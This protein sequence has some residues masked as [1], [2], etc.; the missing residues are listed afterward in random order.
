M[1][2]NFTVIS[3][4]IF[5][6][7]ISPASLQKWASQFEEA[8][9]DLLEIM[10]KNFRYFNFNSLSAKLRALHERLI[11]RYGKDLTFISVGHPSK[12]GDLI[13]YFYR[14]EN[15]LTSDSFEQFEDIGMLSK[16]AGRTLVFLDD[17]SGSGRQAE[18]LWHSIR[19]KI[20]ETDIKAK[21]VYATIV[22]LSRARKR[23][24]INSHLEF[25]SELELGSEQALFSDD[26]IIVPEARTRDRLHKMA[27]KYG[28]RIYPSHPLGYSESG[29]LIA[30][31]YSTPN[32]TL[33]LFWAKTASWHPLLPH[34]EPLRDRPS[35]IG[36]NPAWL[37]KQIPPD[38]TTSSSKD[39]EHTIELALLVLNEFKSL[40]AV[41]A[42]LPIF[43]ALHLGSGVARK[44]VELARDLANTKNEGTA[45]A[46]SILIPHSMAAVPLTIEAPEKFE[47]GLKAKLQERSRGLDG[48]VAAVVVNEQGFVQGITF[49]PEASDGRVGSVPSRL[50]SAAEMSRLTKSLIIVGAGDGRTDILFD[51]YLVLSLR[52]GK[53]N[54]LDPSISNSILLLGRTHHLSGEGFI[55][56]VRMC[57]QISD[58]NRG[59]AFVCF[60][61]PD[62]VLKYADPKT[63]SELPNF[64]I[65]STSEQILLGI[66]RQD[67]AAI[68]SNE[69]RIVRAMTTLRPPQDVAN[70]RQLPGKGTKHQTAAVISA[71]TQSLCITVSADGPITFFSK[72]QPVLRLFA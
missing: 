59:G 9:Q 24:E 7:D 63:G 34:S 43:S 69:G 2:P 46:T 29:C 70:V 72:G 35:L 14:K 22:A 38:S 25:V 1:H 49:F 40:R 48:H 37:D 8:E 55:D 20:S 60:G 28:N 52:D 50:R 27:L 12:S 71:L 23:L 51:G 13:G 62:N 56:I 19:A 3:E 21:L 47:I 6:G 45:V 11:D 64:E 10:L 68:L 66:F 17:F 41:N 33:P 31:F 54:Y 67:G 4:T 18:R 58:D 42:L 16:H 44:I 39:E 57:L 53:W 61:D 26:S 65:G 15:H 36:L 32:N 30:F 5:S